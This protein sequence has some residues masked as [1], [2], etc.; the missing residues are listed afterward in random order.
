[1][2]PQAVQAFEDDQNLKV[3]PMKKEVRPQEELQLTFELQAISPGIKK[4]D[5][6]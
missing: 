5:V 2:N 4:N 3:F 1:M 6:S